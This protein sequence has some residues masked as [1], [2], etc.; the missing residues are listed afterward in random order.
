MF[1]VFIGK[2]R[3]NIAAIF[4][5]GFVVAGAFMIPTLEKEYTYT[6]TVIDT[7]YTNRRL[8]ISSK[9]DLTFKLTDGVLFV[10]NEKA[11]T[12]EVLRSDI[13]TLKNIVRE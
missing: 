12:T 3:R 10:K 7:D 2:I 13:R 5:I 4:L 9:D 8:T 6:I 11:N 1:K